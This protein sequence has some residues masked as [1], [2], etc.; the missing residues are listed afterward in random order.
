MV[1]EKPWHSHASLV[2]EG[3]CCYASMVT[4]YTIFCKI[5][6]LQVDGCPSWPCWPSTRGKEYG[7]GSAPYKPHAAAWRALLGVC[8]SHGNGEMAQNALSNEF[9]N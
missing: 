4:D 7:H 5:G 6:T 9:L 3:M 8:K 2:D 1:E